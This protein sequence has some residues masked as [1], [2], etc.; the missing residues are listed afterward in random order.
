MSNIEDL[1]QKVISWAYDRN[2]I[3]GSTYKEQYMKAQSELGEL[4]DALL[5]ADRDGMEDAIGDVL[6]CIINLSEQLDTTLEHCLS[7][8]YDSIKDRKGIMFNGV[9]VKETDENYE[10][11]LNHLN[12]EFK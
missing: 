2:I 3:S 1:I 9:F 4:A 10:R 8:A 11:I 7:R 12:G 5:K 6:V